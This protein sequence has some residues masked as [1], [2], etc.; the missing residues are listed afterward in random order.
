MAELLKIHP[1]NPEGR[2]IAHVVDV[3]KKGGIV[4]Y[5]TDTIYGIGCDLMNRKSIERVRSGGRSAQSVAARL[6]SDIARRGDQ[7]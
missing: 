3:L 6:R 4:V 7:R 2:K 1:Q 5:P